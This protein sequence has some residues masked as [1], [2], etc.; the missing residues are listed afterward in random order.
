[1]S[2]DESI[3]S[4]E[5]DYRSDAGSESYHASTENYEDSEII[6]KHIE[7]KIPT[8]RNEIQN[9][10]KNLVKAN[11]STISASVEDDENY[12]AEFDDVS[13][14]YS[15]DFSFE[16]DKS[17]VQKELLDRITHTNRN[18]L[19]PLPPPPQIQLPSIDINSLQ[20]E[21][22]LE[23]IGKEVIRLRNQ[24]RILLHERRL[25]A[26]EKKI[27]ADTRRAKYE[28]EFNE[29]RK[30]IVES[31]EKCNVLNDHADSTQRTL[32]S[33]I[34]NKQLLMKDIEINQIESNDMRLLVESLQNKL[35]ISIHDSGTFRSIC[36][37]V[38]VLEYIPMLTMY[39]SFRMCI[40]IV[41]MLSYDLDKEKNEIHKREESWTDERASLKAEVQR[42]NLLA[43]VVQQSLEINE[44][45]LAKE[46]ERLPEEHKRLL[47]EQITRSRILEGSLL[48]REGALRA[49]EMRR[50][51]ELNVRAKEGTEELNRS[52]MRF[53]QELS[54]ERAALRHQKSTLDQDK[55]AFE[56]LMSKE[57]GD[58]AILNINIS[59]KEAALL[60]EL[61]TLNRNRVEFAA[62]KDAVEPMLRETND[63]R[64]TGRRY[65]KTAEKILKDAESQANG[66]LEAEK[67]L[68]AMEEEVLIRE[69]KAEEM[70]S[71]FGKA[72]KLLQN[73]AIQ[74][75]SMQKELTAE[76]FLLHGAA[77]ELAS[78]ASEIRRTVGLMSKY[79]RLSSVMGS[80]GTAHRK[81]L[82]KS[83]NYDNNYNSNENYDDSN[84]NK[85][86]YFDDKM[87]TND[88]NYFND[89]ESNEK[90]HEN[91]DENNENHSETHSDKSNKQRYQGSRA[92]MNSSAIVNSVDN[93]DN[94][95]ISMQKLAEKLSKNPKKP[96]NFL[97]ENIHESNNILENTTYDINNS[98][99]LLNGGSDTDDNFK[100][101]IEVDTYR[102]DR[103]IPIT[104]NHEYTADTVKQ[105]RHSDNG[106]VVKSDKIDDI[107]SVEDF[108][109][110]LSIDSAADLSSGLKAAAAKYG[111]YQ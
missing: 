88:R 27:R 92:S 97:K 99:Q 56:S 42:S 47:E 108:N 6:P 107:Y 13:A 86:Y 7:K 60:M 94:I 109:L 75:S 37:D 85:G 46:R 90:Y 53:D 96:V 35:M 110:R 103:N 80:N 57:K 51:H 19:L 48:E 17:T 101:D 65:L 39:I 44:A 76:R 36:R 20:A 2:D 38:F 34:A 33:Y 98:F 10:N 8:D 63:D 31:E 93:L 62:A 25:I 32:D 71:R 91:Y 79:E 72:Q 64:E 106:A 23:E 55:I 22:A 82:K 21:I 68:H 1:M 67:G 30:K 87:V 26:K 14:A 16:V 12:S 69:E 81:D 61:S 70:M 43:S 73:E 74:I 84:V 52:R 58:I 4:E 100:N 95:N 24:Q 49:E 29:M 50:T 102:N 104:H 45:R 28:Y 11:I 66:V 111:I 9:D 54:E 83:Y 40:L 41:M 78:Q 15:N 105:R 3:I 77:I 5:I 59:R 89:Y 18:A